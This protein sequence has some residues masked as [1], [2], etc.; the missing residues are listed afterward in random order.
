MPAQVRM[1]TFLTGREAGG[2]KPG[3][4]LHAASIG[5]GQEPDFEPFAPDQPTMEQRI[6]YAL[7]RPSAASNEGKAQWGTSG[8][9]ASVP[10]KAVSIEVISSSTVASVDR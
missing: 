7:G 5:Y 3:D 6:A 10:Y 2:T 9:A 4:S 8:R 1:H